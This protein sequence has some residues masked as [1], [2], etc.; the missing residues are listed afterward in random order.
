LRRLNTENHLGNGEKVDIQSH[1]S[2]TE[3]HDDKRRREDNFRMRAQMKFDN[4][5]VKMWRHKCG[6]R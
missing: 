4:V 3:Q 6:D 5:N 1:S 2:R